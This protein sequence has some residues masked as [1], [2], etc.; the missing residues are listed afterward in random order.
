VGAY[1]IG[2][3]SDKINLSPFCPITGLTSGQTYY[4]KVSGSVNGVVSPKS[5]EASATLTLLPPTNPMATPSAGQVALSWTAS[6]GATSYNVYVGTSA[7]GESSSP[8]LTGV[9]GTNVNVTGLYNSSTYYFK[10]AAVRGSTVSARSTEVSATTPATP[11]PT[12]LTAA[13]SGT[14]QITLNWTASPGALYYQ[15]YQGTTAGGEAAGAVQGG[16]KTTSTT[17]TGLTSGQ[18]YYFKVSGSVN[19]V[20][21]P[22]SSE[23]SA[24]AN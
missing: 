24:T 13:A 7:G 4:F 16:I 18:T 23:A 20:V 11:A 21:S 6:S 12:N 22:K 9:T 8:R 19:G 10:L 15:V 3:S 5:N 1:I 17:I 14:G 2:P